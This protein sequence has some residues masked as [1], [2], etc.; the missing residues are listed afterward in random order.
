MI[1]FCVNLRNLREKVCDNLTSLTN[2]ICVHCPATFS[3]CY[4][5]KEDTALKLK[6]QQNLWLHPLN[7][8]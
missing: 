4:K 8:F 3:N 1:I 5:E 2:S 6:F 7:I